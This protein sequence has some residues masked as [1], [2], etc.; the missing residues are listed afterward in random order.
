MRGLIDE[1]PAALHPQ[2][3]LAERW[4]TGEALGD[5]HVVHIQQTYN[6][7]TQLERSTDFTAWVHHARA[8]NTYRVCGQGERDIKVLQCSERKSENCPLFISPATYW[9]IYYY[10]IHHERASITTILPPT[11]ALNRKEITQMETYHF[12]WGTKFLGSDLG[13]LPWER[14]VE[15]KREKGEG[16]T[17]E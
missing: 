6:H 3:I 4:Q 13:S 2:L 15:R 12:I 14:G 1:G 7:I 10:R 16:V 9:A 5:T 17:T 8:K 11:L